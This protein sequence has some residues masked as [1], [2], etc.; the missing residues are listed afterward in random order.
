MQVRTAMFMD[1]PAIAD[2]AEDARARSV[3]SAFATLERDA[4]K[5]TLF[6]LIGRHGR[7]D[8]GGAR[9]IVAGDDV[10]AGALVGICDRLY[11]ALDVRLVTDLFWYVRPGTQAIVAGRMAKDLHDWAERMPKPTILR[12]GVTSAI[13]DIEKT[14]KILARTGME[15]V[16]YIYE[17]GFVE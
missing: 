11:Q 15:H 14:R 10:L 9:V 7:N 16:G 6:D 1:I 13:A 8:F 12:Q 4:L 17:K 3:Y 2:L 5:A